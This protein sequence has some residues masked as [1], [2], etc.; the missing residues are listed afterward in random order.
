MDP[1][2]D[3]G[4][5]SVLHSIQST[6]DPHRKLVDRSFISGGKPSIQMVPEFL[7]SIKNVERLFSPDIVAIGPY[8]RNEKRLQ[9]MEDIKKMAANEFCSSTVHQVRAFY[10]NVQEVAEQARES[11][12][13]DVHMNDDDF[14]AMLFFDGCFLL[15]FMT[16][17]TL[18]RG[19]QKLWTMPRLSENWMQRISRDILL[20]ENQIPW[21]VLEALMRLKHVLVDRYI[22]DT[23]SNFDVKGA[24]PQ[25]DFELEGANKYQP[26][27]LLD[28]VRHRQI[29]P[30][31]SR[32][33]VADEVPRPI[34]NISSALELAEVGVHITAGKTARLSDMGVGKNPLFGNLCLPPVYL[35]EL[36]MSLLINMAA[37]EM[38]QGGTSDADYGASSYM[39]IMAV[40]MNREDDVRQLRAKRILYPVFSDQ[41][42][43]D[44]FKSV[45]PYLR[46]GGQYDRVLQRLSDYQQDRTV[47][48]TLHKFV[49]NN[50]TYLL[51][52][53]SAFGLLIPILRAVLSLKDAN[54]CAPGAPPRAL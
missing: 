39:Q 12:A 53:G 23:I 52:S 25:V 49:Y 17:V 46:K 18:D 6:T 15:Q 31:R 3:T 24:K 30:F 41:E 2:N 1:H 27:H 45:C 26:L 42:T 33:A 48:I 47:R 35:S 34:L 51:T 32:M 19:P 8:H 11:Y 13:Q 22:A 10:L 37:F 36:T 21:V 43:L 38:L 16:M 4:L 14:T 54:R 28:L 20:V 29:G 5:D 44:F 50:L 40:L 7:R 9:S